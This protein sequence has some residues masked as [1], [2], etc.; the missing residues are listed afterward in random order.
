[1][2]V[3]AYPQAVDEQNFLYSM[4]NVNSNVSTVPEAP[5]NE[6]TLWDYGLWNMED[7]HGRNNI[8]SACFTTKACRIW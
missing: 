3:A 4:L 1:M 8:S 7:F 5:I 6:D 2:A